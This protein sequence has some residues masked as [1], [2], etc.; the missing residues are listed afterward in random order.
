MPTLAQ[1]MLA[2]MR[3]AGHVGSYMSSYAPNEAPPSGRNIGSSSAQY[4]RAGLQM[5][6]YA[7]AAEAFSNTNPDYA[8]ELS[9]ISA[10]SN[11]RTAYYDRALLWNQFFF[12]DP[13]G[14]FGQ[15]AG[16]VNNTRVKAWGFEFWIKSKSTGQWVRRAT[17][18]V[19][20]GQGERPNFAVT[21]PNIKDERTESDGRVSIR[22][23]RDAAAI[24]GYYIYHGYA[25]GTFLIDP[26]DVADAICLMRTSLVVHD[27]FEA[28][29]RR[30][31]RM[32]A[33]VGG[34]WKPDPNVP[35]SYFPGIG[36]SRHKLVTARWPD[37]QFHVMATMTE[38]QMAL[39]GGYPTEFNSIVEGSGTVVDP[40]DPT[41]PLA[42][43]PG[44]TSPAW[45][46]L[47]DGSYTNWGSY[48]TPTP[49]NKVRRG[50]RAKL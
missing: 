36:T 44:R 33:A 10:G 46:P 39:P 29:D 28:D 14:P 35:M 6:R 8:A 32:V 15:P 2:D 47:L 13:W 38:A 50:R 20:T 25:G 16:W 18:D 24:G 41:P 1:V 22:L 40:G 12:A 26:Y 9:Y 21:Y 5:G 27:P 19:M 45:V 42:Q 4:Y 48:A 3:I 30:F 43:L 34:D 17:S 49:G 7:V 23:V 37:W 11:M 31:A